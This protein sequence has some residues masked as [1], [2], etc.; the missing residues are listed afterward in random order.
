MVIM[1]ENIETDN[2]YITRIRFWDLED[3]HAAISRNALF[4]SLSYGKATPL[5][6][7]LS[8]HTSLH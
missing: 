3:L 7:T 5:Q 8:V 4:V 6:I 1:N 2:E